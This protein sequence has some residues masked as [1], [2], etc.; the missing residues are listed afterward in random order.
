MRRVTVFA[1]A[2]VLVGSAACGG[3]IRPAYSPFVNARID[4]VNAEPADVVQEIASRVVAEGMRINWN[5][6]EEGFVETQWYDLVT[7]Q[8]GQT[9]RSNPDR[10][11]LLRFWADPIGPGRSKLTAEAVLKRTT[12]P[13]VLPREQEMM[14]PPGHGGMR[15]LDRVIVGLHERFG[16]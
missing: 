16:R 9:S 7:R 1:F 14:V 10:V 6:P 5:S 15:L 2:A 3:G 4:T 11:I 12:D 13:S 8:S